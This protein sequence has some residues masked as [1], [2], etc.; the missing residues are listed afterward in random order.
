MKTQKRPE[1][2]YTGFKQCSSCGAKWSN[3]TR[4]LED[5][6]IKLIGYQVNF[7]ALLAGFFLFNHSCMTT[8]AIPAEAFE[9]LY[10]GPVFSERATGSEE[11]PEHCIHENDLSP[12]PAHCECAFVR[13]IIQSVKAWPKR[14]AA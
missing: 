6:S 5:P 8:L 14:K 10:D 11:C 12:C 7:E 3:R 4:F 1:E 2:D 13:E 9:D